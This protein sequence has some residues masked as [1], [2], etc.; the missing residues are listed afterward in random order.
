[1]MK[2]TK[3]EL[4]YIPDLK[5]YRFFEKGT[6]GVVS[7]ISNRYSKTNNIYLKTYDP[8]KNQNIYIL[9]RK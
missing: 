4:E 3:I 7:S 5:M 2:M 8:N 1:M 6:R 9:R